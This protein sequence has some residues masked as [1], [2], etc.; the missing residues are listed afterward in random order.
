MH[1]TRH[2]GFSLIEVL[3]AIGI[4]AMAMMAGMAVSMTLTRFAERQ[5]ELVL[6]QLCAQNEY[7]R[8]RLQHQFP[9]LGDTITSCTQGGREFSVRLSVTA[10]E[11]PDFRQ[12]RT[13]IQQSGASNLGAAA[14]ETQQ[15]LLS[16]STVIGRY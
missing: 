7:A 11:N 13:Q 9:E 16:V 15:V 6:A 5:P 8:L 1:M 4:V 14:S 2:A 3:V 12:I 10:T